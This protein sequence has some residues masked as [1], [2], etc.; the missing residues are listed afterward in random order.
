M[1]LDPGEDRCRDESLTHPSSPG[2][3]ST[4]EAKLGEAIKSLKERSLKQRVLPPVLDG[5]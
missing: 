1:E 5:T 2:A 3:S 4:S